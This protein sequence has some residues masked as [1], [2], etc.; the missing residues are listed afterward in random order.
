MNR[1]IMNSVTKKK[2][3]SLKY[4]EGIYFRPSGSKEV[5]F[6]LGSMLGKIISE[7]WNSRYKGTKTGRNLGVVR[8]YIAQCPSR[9]HKI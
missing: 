7:R 9:C 3:R 2:G 5:I 4:P 1:S 8:K 6:E